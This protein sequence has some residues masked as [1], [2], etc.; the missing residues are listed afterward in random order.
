M[1][2]ELKLVTDKPIL[3]VL[4]LR[5]FAT[6]RRYRQHSLS[7]NHSLLFCLEPISKLFEE[8]GDAGELDKPEE[9]GRLV[10]PANEEPPF[11]LEPGKEAFDEPAPF[12]PA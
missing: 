2:A 9:A 12:V 11:P 1:P 7:F 10:L 4:L 6:L 3:L 8:H 5:D